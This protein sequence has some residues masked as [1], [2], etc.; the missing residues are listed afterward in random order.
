[1]PRSSIVPALLAQLEGYLQGKAC[2][3]EEVGAAALP[4][5]L[6]GKINLTAVAAEMGLS[7]TQRQHLYKPQ[8]A[9]VLNEAAARQNAHGIGYR[10]RRRDP[11]AAQ[12]DAATSTAVEQIAAAERRASEAMQ[13]LAE[14]EALLLS[15]RREIASLREQLRLLEETGMVMRSAPT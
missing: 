6:D 3:S 8:I 1:M 13:L 9:V 7:A 11:Q 4:L 2:G 10:Q 15:Q 12:P 5:T 14:R